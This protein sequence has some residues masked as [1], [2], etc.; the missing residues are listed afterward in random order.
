VGVVLVHLLRLLV[1]VPWPFKVLRKQRGVSYECLTEIA[2]L[3]MLWI[4]T[5]L[6]MPDS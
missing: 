4:P 2:I 3:R 1:N 6:S 5:T